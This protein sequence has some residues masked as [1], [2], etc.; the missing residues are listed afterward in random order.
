MIINNNKNRATKEQTKNSFDSA[1][2]EQIARDKSYS[3]NERD[4]H[5]FFV[6]SI[7]LFI[8]CSF[9]SLT[10]WKRKWVKQ[11]RKQV[12]MRNKK[13]M[14]E[15][16]S[17]LVSLQAAKLNLM[18]SLH[19]PLCSY[20]VHFPSLPSFHFFILACWW[21]QRLD[22]SSCFLV[23]LLR[24][25][26]ILFFLLLLLIARNDVTLSVA[27]IFFTFSSVAAAD[28]FECCFRSFVRITWVCPEACEWLV[29]C[30]E[31]ETTTTRKG[32]YK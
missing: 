2:D 26:F 17:A 28:T 23:V 4:T 16:K 8:F 22:V 18:F 30:T 13:N 6:I 20:F 31:F 10:N 19:S 9:F 29:S 25:F 27:V 32:K 21:C 3:R 7:F 14:S 24:S 15:K 12:R 5:S 1:K 11:R